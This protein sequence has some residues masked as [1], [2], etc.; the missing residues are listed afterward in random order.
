MTDYMQSLTA[1]DKAAGKGSLPFVG[2]RLK[3]LQH[4]VEAR[5]AAGRVA[6]HHFA[7]VRVR[8]PI[9]PQSA[10]PSE[11]SIGSAFRASQAAACWPGTID[12]AIASNTRQPST[13]PPPWSLQLQNLR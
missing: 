3:H 1:F 4:K 10:K 12:C 13:A 9:V 11:A 5:Q 8:R 2:G 6:T 7:A